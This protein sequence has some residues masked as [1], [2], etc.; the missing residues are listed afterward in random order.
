MR[1]SSCRWA[2]PIS[3]FCGLGTGGGWGRSALPPPVPPQVLL[4]SDCCV[5]CWAIRTLAAATQ[6]LCPC[7]YTAVTRLQ[8]GIKS[9][10]SGATVRLSLFLGNK[11]AETLT[12]VGGRLAG[13]I[14]AWG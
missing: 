2:H 11:A 4:L 8:V 13:R 9:Q 6:A 5:H 1:T 14:N 3:W 12:Q 10:L 7:S